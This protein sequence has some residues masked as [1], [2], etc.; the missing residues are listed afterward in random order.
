MLDNLIHTQGSRDV[1]QLAAALMV[2]NSE[3]YVIL[4]SALSSYAV[5]T[6][7]SDR[8]SGS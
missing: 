2:K 7:Y 3:R 4:C 1:I 8:L 5:L 6:K